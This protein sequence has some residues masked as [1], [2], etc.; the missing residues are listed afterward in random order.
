MAFFKNSMILRKIS[1]YYLIP[2][3]I[4]ANKEINY[5]YLI[6]LKKSIVQPY[7]K[8]MAGDA[9]HLAMMS[10]GIIN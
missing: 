1:R 2:L 5:L 4:E 8:N 7:Y 3:K 10:E 6:V 9:C